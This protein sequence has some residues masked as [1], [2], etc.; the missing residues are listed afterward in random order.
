MRRIFD[1]TLSLTIL[2]SF[3]TCGVLLF[4]D[5]SKDIEEKSRNLRSTIVLSDHQ[6]PALTEDG[7]LDVATVEEV[8]NGVAY[9]NETSEN[10]DIQDGG[11]GK[12]I[13]AQTNTYKN[14]VKFTDGANCWDT[15]DHYGAQCWDLA[16]LFWQN[17][18]GRRL[19]TCGTGMAKGIWDCKEQV[20]SNDFN[21]ITNPKNLQ[22]GDWIIFASGK[23]GHIGMAIGKYNN[24]YV[25]LYGQNQG[26]QYCENGGSSPN[27]INI[28]LKTFK[29]AF[30]PKS[31]V[32]KP[33]S[34]KY[35]IV[36]KN[37]N[38]TKIAKKYKITVKKILKL[39]KNIKNAN[40]IYVNQKIRVK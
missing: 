10:V 12:F 13:Y 26:G 14:F 28:S 1:F 6:V 4:N 27:V 3:V 39:N 18:A 20:A 19:S 34:K 25:A 9:V 31:Y 21:L 38:L 8:D 37:E 30:R 40:L 11:L 23:Y 24:G 29:G 22:E 36:K 32:I 35:H 7:I 5:F 15:D 17:Y 16:D 2:L 33:K